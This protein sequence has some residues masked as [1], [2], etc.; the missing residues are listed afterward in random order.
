M[1]SYFHS[2]A[3]GLQR[4]NN[5]CGYKPVKI[6]ALVIISDL[7]AVHCFFLFLIMHLVSAKLDVLFLEEHVE[8][9]ETIPSV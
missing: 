8:P 2:F 3:C 1:F 7:T 4:H 9:T 6:T 5:T